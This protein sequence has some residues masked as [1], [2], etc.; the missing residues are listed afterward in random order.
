[1]IFLE[2]SKKNI[3]I[4]AFSILTVLSIAFALFFSSKNLTGS[5]TVLLND[6]WTITI[7]ENT[8]HDISINDYLFPTLGKDE[9]IKLTNTL[10]NVTLLNNP[11]LK[12]H[13][14]HSYVELYFNG[15]LIY[16]YGEDLSL[17]NQLLGYG[18]HFIRIPSDYTNATIEIIMHVTENDA[19][20]SI[21]VPQICDST[22][23]FRDL[24]IDNRIPLAINMFLI[25]FGILIVLIS[26]VFFF[27]NRNFLKLICVG[28]FSLGIGLWSLCNY[29]LISLFTYDLRVKAYMEFA[30]LYISPLFV[31]LYF[32]GDPFV[33]MNR[34]VNTLYKFLLSAQFLFTLTAFILQAA[35][36][37][38][39]PSLL[40]IQH[41]LM[42]LLCIGFIALTIYDIVKK[43][44]K[45]L[46]LTLGM[47]SL[48]IV[49]LLDLIKFSAAKYLFMADDA[50]FT[51]NLCIGALLFVISQLIDFGAKITD[52]FIIGARAKLLEQMA[53]I[54][55]LTGVANRRR[56]EE[57]WDELDHSDSNY[58]I[59]SFDLNLLKSTNDSFGHSM[60]DLLI[61]TFAKCLRKVFEQYGTVG[62]IGGDEF[63][64]IIPDLTNIDIQQLLTQLQNEIQ[65]F[66]ANS[67][68]LNLSTAYGFCSHNQ[69]PKYDSRKIY[70]AAD[71]YM[72]QQKSNS[73]EQK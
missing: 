1:M 46:I 35:N 24:I 55:A 17:T 29:D 60:G 50:S 31:L 18:Y 45:T 66:N 8:F 39:F 33:T 57:L 37:L 58:G 4:I 16:S 21:Y 44:L 43:Q 54:D 5:N 72:Y 25:V 64:V 30:A 48:I 56:C 9:T 70:K 26:I 59:F 15:E 49:G 7:N 14:I 28:C 40:R 69:F 47:S 11:V 62:R 27:I 68:Q 67:P 61:Q 3:L 71:A 10:T 2:K 13:S 65:D 23:M 20:S 51:S 19:F 12:L 36:I 38:H 63:L 34:I 53:Y 32:W 42:L 73:K 6:N 41:L 52:I 22:T